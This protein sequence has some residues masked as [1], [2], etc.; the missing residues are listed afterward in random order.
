MKRFWFLDGSFDITP[1]LPKEWN[2]MSL[3]KI[4]AF[5]IEHNIKVERKG[6]VIKVIVTAPGI[7]YR[8]ENSFADGETV[9]VMFGR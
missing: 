5:G 8:Y 6:E 4:M 1:R 9:S 2:E 7:N 3:D